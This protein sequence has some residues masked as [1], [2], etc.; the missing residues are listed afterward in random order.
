MRAR[1]LLCLVLLLSPAA[2]VADELVLSFGWPDDVPVDSFL[3]TYRRANDPGGVLQQF[4]VPYATPPTCA[5]VPGAETAN[6]VCVRT[7]ECLSPGMYT[8]SVQGESGED[9]SDASNWLTCDALANCRYD[10]ARYADINAAV[11]TSDPQQEPPAPSTDQPP[12]LFPAPGP[13]GQGG[14]DRLREL[15]AELE[16]LK[17]LLDQTPTPVTM[18]PT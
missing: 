17:R 10:C 2:S 14:T 16:Q 13:Q 18:T 8:F 6:Q 4:R 7:P 9:K 5:A 12:P 1:T 15:Q 11:D 3:F